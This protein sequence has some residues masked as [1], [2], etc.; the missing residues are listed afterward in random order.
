MTWRPTSARHTKTTVIDAAISMKKVGLPPARS[1][2]S[3]A[4]E[5][6][7]PPIRPNATA[8][9]TPVARTAVG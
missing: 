6:K 8:V 7:T 1:A 9:P 3:P 2:H 5:L 4:Y